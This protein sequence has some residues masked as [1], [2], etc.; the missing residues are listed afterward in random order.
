MKK[1]T[2][3]VLIGSLL[4]ILLQGCLI[5]NLSNEETLIPIISDDFAV[6]N[7][8]TVT[9]TNEFI[10][11][12]VSA[13]L[14]PSSP[15][16]TFSFQLVYTPSIIPTLKSEDAIVLLRRM[17]TQNGGCKLPCWWGITP[18]ETRWLDARE[19]LNSFVERIEE[20]TYIEQEEDGSPYLIESA[21]IYFE[22]GVPEPPYSSNA[23]G[24]FGIRSINGIV[25]SI[26]ASQDVTSQYTLQKILT[27]N[28]P[29]QNIY[30]NTTSASPT[31]KV[32]FSLLLDFS[33]KGFMAFYHDDAP[34]IGDTIYFCA[35]D[36]APII[37]FIWS[38]SPEVNQK[39]KE[40]F[41]EW[42]DYWIYDD[43][44][45]LPIQ[46]ASNLTL[47]QFY[48]NFR[49]DNPA[50]IVT[51]PPIWDNL[52]PSFYY[53]LLTSTPSPVSPFIETV[54]PVVTP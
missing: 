1:H 36:Y 33:G 51:S 19:M 39:E 41:I 37:L 32:P 8:S 21:L 54:I 24:Y 44:G 16:P 20:D 29:P 53:D 52:T 12:T 25:E 30:I 34:I 22:R 10:I 38:P 14:P 46:D 9:I 23:P 42:L 40:N 47:E 3:S 26:T 49:N 45:L 13:T 35:E 18:G 48:V 31:G 17:L 2:K 27:E 11:P 7:L 50:C 43:S 28:G 4:T 6:Q 5:S 15:T